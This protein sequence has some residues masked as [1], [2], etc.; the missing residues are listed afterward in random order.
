[1]RHIPTSRDDTEEILTNNIS[2][3]PKL[4]K[5]NNLGIDKNSG[6]IFL[7]FYPLALKHGSISI[8][9]SS[10]SIRF[11]I[12]PLSFV[13]VPVEEK[14]WPMT[15][16][17]I[18]NK[19]SFIPLAVYILID[20]PSIF[21]IE[22]IHASMFISLNINAKSFTFGL[23]SHPRTFVHPIFP[24]RIRTHSMR[25]F[26]IHFS[27]VVVAIV[28]LNSNQIS[29]PCPPCFIYFH[30]FFFS[31]LKIIPFSL[32]STYRSFLILYI[33]RYLLFPLQII[34][35]SL[36][37]QQHFF[38]LANWLHFG[39]T[40]FLHWA[41][42]WKFILLPIFPKFLL[43]DM[44]WIFNWYEVFFYNKFIILFEVLLFL[45]FMYLYLFWKLNFQ[46]LWS[47]LILL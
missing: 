21:L 38:V 42:G 15:V 25:H 29:N 44:Y 11:I 24:G 6:P 31:F 4:L 33:C 2:K 28:V 32:V 3:I 35:L 14:I 22:F 45:L 40:H 20:P 39:L 17:I 43:L 18:V 37:F 8:D 9:L 47:F 19:I 46:L 41:Y 34:R 12:C 30:R 7:I 27:K 5:V 1:M 36:T 26:P 10:R 23:T 16:L 13:D